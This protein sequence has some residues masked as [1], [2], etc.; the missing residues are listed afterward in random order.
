MT[1]EREMAER[2]DTEDYDLLTYGEVGA[3]MS[4]SLA[5]EQ[6]ALRELRSAAAPDPA[7][8]KAAEARIAQL[9]EAAARYRDQ[10]R[11]A[12]AFMRRFGLPPRRRQ[13]D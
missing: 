4:E 10:S 8:I 2:P 7:A 13:A 3:R 5:G 12:E 11:T 6:R 9:T 1:E